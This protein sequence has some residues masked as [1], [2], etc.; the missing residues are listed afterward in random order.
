MDKLPIMSVSGIRGK[1]GETL[2]ETFV[3]RISFIQT[4]ASGGGNIVIGRDTRPT[5]K[6]LMRAAARGIRAAGGTPVD[7]GIAPT[8]TTCVA[9]SA[10]DASGGIIITASHNPLPYNGYKMVHKSGRLFR[11]EECQDVYKKFFD[12]DYP[13]DDELLKYIDEPAQ[14]I[15]AASIH[16]ERILSCVDVGLIRSKNISV[17]VDSING[18]AGAV[19]PMLLDKL[20]VRWRG[21]H[22][23]LN[24][25]FVHNPEP[26]PEHL[27]DLRQLLMS[28]GGFWGGFVFD[29]DADRL[30]TMGEGGQEVSEEMTLALA[31]Q[32]I[33]AKDKTG[34][35]TNL[36]TSM[37]IDDVA[38]LYGISVVRTKIGEANV[39]KGMEDNGCR[40]G[41][42]GNGGVI[43]P[44]ISWCRDGLA[45]LA[46]ILEEMAK[47]GQKLYQLASRWPHY[48]IV[49]DKISCDGIN[50]AALIEKLDQRFA[51]ENKDLT[52]GLKIIRDDG[53]VH[54]RASNTEPIIRCY[55]EAK[56]PEAARQL[57]DMM[58]FAAEKV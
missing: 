3:S 35:A 44:R 49:K 39:V 6:A 10:L 22:N 8:P 54:L 51:G 32:N 36:S 30:A 47:T 24:G 31:L 45:G 33:L 20:S 25:D 26:R 50:P 53:W 46:L 34:V 7:I 37:L 18:A 16:I 4:R 41:G 21:V 1:Y 14:T 9:V 42:E 12:G 48:H 19:F 40:A 52:D 17:A 11:D 56:S 15:D 27:G 5:G 29:P 55:A 38:R 43:F 28:D 13:G 2:D 58:L 57:A 23:K